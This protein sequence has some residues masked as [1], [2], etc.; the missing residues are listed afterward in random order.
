VLGLLRGEPGVDRGVE[1]GGLDRD[2]DLSGREVGH[3]VIEDGMGTR[4]VIPLILWK[5]LDGLGEAQCRDGGGD[6]LNEWGLGSQERVAGH[7]CPQFLK[8]GRR[9][10][11]TTLPGVPM[12]ASARYHLPVR[13]D[14]T[15]ATRLAPQRS[16]VAAS[17]LAVAIW[18]LML[19]AAAVLV[20]MSIS[21]S[22]GSHYLS[23]IRA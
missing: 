22:G 9:G 7:C 21:S 5:V 15:Q 1:L 19:A 10:S 11:G 18:R 13:C 4:S 3:P 2:G 6:P 16:Q 8:W 17:T 14:L 23:T 12:V 20:S